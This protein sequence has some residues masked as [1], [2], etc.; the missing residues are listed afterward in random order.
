MTD[1]ASDTPATRRS[2][3]TRAR[4][5]AAARVLFAR[6]GYHSVRPQDV[7]REAGV[8]QGTFYQY[9]DGKLECFLAFSRLV[10]EELNAA[11]NEALEGAVDFKDRLCRAVTAI[12][13]W[14]GAHP[15]ELL[16]VQIDSRVLTAENTTLSPVV[17]RWA[18]F[19]RGQLV[20]GQAEGSVRS[21]I[22]LRVAG[23]SVLGVVRGSFALGRARGLSLSEVLD[24]IVPFIMA[25]V[26][27]REDGR[28]APR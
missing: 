2:A 7:A 26:G 14:S 6:D 15:R 16:T 17:D 9:F 27:T 4:L 11:V 24:H 5:L 8:A 21:D 25:G 3:E 10:D 20:A 19:W 23:G 18:E 28:S 12:W 13:D 22:D 1:A